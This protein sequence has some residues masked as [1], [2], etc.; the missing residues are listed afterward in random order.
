MARL[1]CFLRLKGAKLTMMMIDYVSISGILLLF[2]GS[3][4]KDRTYK[5]KGLR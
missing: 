4:R 5:K 1:W 3:Y 2:I